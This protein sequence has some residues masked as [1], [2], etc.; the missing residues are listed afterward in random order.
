MQYIILMV[1]QVY[2]SIR[3]IHN[4]CRFVKI[5]ILTWTLGPQ[6]HTFWLKDDVFR[7]DCTTIAIL[8]ELQGLHGT[9]GMLIHM[10]LR[11]ED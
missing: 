11:T 8:L 5:A 10:R 6:A 9:T 7:V 2:T 4:R 3:K 1:D